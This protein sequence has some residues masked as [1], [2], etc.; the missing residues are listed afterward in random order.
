[1]R[2]KLVDPSAF[3]PPYDRALAGALAGA[4]AEVELITSEFL[5]GTV[6]EAVGYEVN[7]CFYRRTAARGLDARGRLPLKLAEHLPDMLRLRGRLDGDVTHYQWLTMPALD[8]LL[9]SRKG[10]KVMTAHYIA[11]PEPKWIELTTAQRTF[12]SMDAVIVHT[13]N[14]ARRLQDLIG[15]PEDRIRVIPHG[16]FDYLTRLPDEAPLPIEL[17]G[18]KGPVILFFG[19]MRPYK[20]IDT[21]LEACAEV[22]GAEL[23]I[24]GNPRMDLVELVERSRKLPVKVR[25]LPRFIEDREIPAIMRA[26]DLLVLPYRDIEQSGVLYTGL[27]FGKA[28]VLSDVGGF[29]EVARKH[30]A[31]RLVPPGDPAALAE[32]ITELTS[33]PAARVALEE[34]AV[35]AA[36]GPYSWDEIAR[37]TI[38]LYREVGA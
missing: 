8:C 34:K 32:A 38:R 12:E 5:Y 19:L 6:P 14:G 4:G 10:P 16:A 30:G 21:L 33:D 36:S 29:G 23:W 17:D 1:M 13:E 9:L 31:A 28:M 24:V 26:A 3:T 27:A 35:A 2:V 11:S 25:W 15:L 37:S 7:E 22:E 20:G 18:A